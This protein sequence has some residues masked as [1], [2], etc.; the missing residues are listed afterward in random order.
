MAGR[1][2]GKQALVLGR[3]LALDR[4][5][6]AKRLADGRVSCHLPGDASRKMSATAAAVS[7]SSSTYAPATIFRASSRR[8]AWFGG[9]LDILVHRWRSQ[10]RI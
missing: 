8:W 6:D 5:G 7:C 10:R 1:F 3:Q 9:G 4:V 2:E